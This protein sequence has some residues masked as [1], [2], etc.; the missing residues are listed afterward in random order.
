MAHMG[1]YF[2]KNSTTIPMFLFLFLLQP[3]CRQQHRQQSVYHEELHCCINSVTVHYG[4]KM[5]GV[6]KVD[7]STEKKTF[8][9]V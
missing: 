3:R 9:V 8:F 2:V 6:T 5:T 4:I 1:H 7:K